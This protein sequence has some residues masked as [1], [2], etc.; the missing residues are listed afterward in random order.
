[1]GK[2]LLWTMRHVPL[3][4]EG[5]YPLRTLAGALAIFGVAALAHGSGFLAVFIAGILV[6]EA[7]AP[8]KREI[9][10]F[11]SALASMGEILAFVVLGLTVHLAD[12]A[13]PRRLGAR[14]GHRGGP[15][16]R[17]ATTRPGAASRPI[18]A[19]PEREDAS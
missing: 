1:M 10:H 9:E 19:R 8:Y 2:A 17:G 12:L 6:G 5:L 4:G 13:D 3:P 15:R 11:H 18:G 14:P 7:R 16:L